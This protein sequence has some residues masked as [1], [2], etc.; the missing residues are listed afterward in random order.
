MA[1]TFDF[2]KTLKRLEDIV[3]RIEGET[4]PLTESMKL[5]DEGKKLIALLE[6]AIA[7]AEKKVAA[8]SDKD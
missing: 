3:A 2:E 1:E 4:L 5:Y 7:A 6:K 8:E